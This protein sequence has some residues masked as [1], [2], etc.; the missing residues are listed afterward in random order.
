MSENCPYLCVRSVRM[1]LLWICP[2]RYKLILAMENAHEFEAAI[3]SK[4]PSYF[5]HS[6]E[7]LLLQVSKT[8]Q[9]KGI[10]YIIPK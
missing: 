10:S 6:S 2:S 9:E 1:M 7:H 5:I 3:Y 8:R 4:K